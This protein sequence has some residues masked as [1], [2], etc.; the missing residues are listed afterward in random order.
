MP[1]RRVGEKE[2]DDRIS[3]SLYFST[4]LP[5]VTS[6]RNTV[7]GLETVPT[8]SPSRATKC[9]RARDLASAPRASPPPSVGI[10]GVLRHPCGRVSARRLL[11]H[12]EWQHRSASERSPPLLTAALNPEHSSGP[13]GNI[14]YSLSTTLSTLSAGGAS[15]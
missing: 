4:R 6:A 8:P 3:V 5:E 13:R 12:S 10:V 1:T 7:L 11:R 15:V 14:N 9:Y 2:T